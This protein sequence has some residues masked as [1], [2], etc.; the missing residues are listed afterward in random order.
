MGFI[1]PCLAQRLAEERVKDALREAE[2]ARLIRVAKSP[3]RRGERAVLRE[4][5]SSVAGW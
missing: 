2:K 3:G 4:L 1:N 5:A